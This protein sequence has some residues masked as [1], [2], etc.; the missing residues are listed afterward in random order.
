MDIK[1]FSCYRPVHR[2]GVHLVILL[3]DVLHTYWV[4]KG[5]RV[6]DHLAHRLVDFVSH[7]KYHP[8]N[9]VL[10]LIG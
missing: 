2:E 9:T 10:S 7:S 1:L 5:M 8:L 6:D 4:S 3:E